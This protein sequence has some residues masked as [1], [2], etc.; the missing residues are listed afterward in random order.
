MIAR[1]GYVRNRCRSSAPRRTGSIAFVGCED[2]SP[3]FS[4]PFFPLM[5]RSISRELSARGIQLVLLMAHSP[6][7][8]QIAS[9]YLP[10]GHVDGAVLVSMHGKRPPDLHSLGVPVVLAGRPFG[11]D[12]DL[13]YVDADNIGGARMA[14]Q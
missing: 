3:V 6:R 13:S 5:L 14:V 10:G 12:D 11:N 4:E 9:R 7:D 8:S 2:N 1:L